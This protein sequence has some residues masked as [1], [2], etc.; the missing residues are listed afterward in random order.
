[1]GE[2]G[3]HRTNLY[4][5]SAQRARGDSDW[6][7]LGPRATRCDGR[8]AL[9]LGRG[10]KGRHAGRRYGGD[11]AGTV[12]EDQSRSLGGGGNGAAIK[13]RSGSSGDRDLAKECSHFSRMAV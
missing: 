4:R 9:V 7:L 12:E 3:T 2:A 1:H 13:Q 6:R 11:R 5:L 10:R 8:D